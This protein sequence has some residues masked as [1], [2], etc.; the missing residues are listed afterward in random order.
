MECVDRVDGLIACV[1][2]VC[3]QSEFPCQISQ[4]NL[5]APSQMW[6]RSNDFNENEIA[7]ANIPFDKRIRPNDWH[8]YCDKFCGNV[9]FECAWWWGCYC[10]CYRCCYVSGLLLLLL[11]LLLSGLLSVFRSWASFFTFI[12][13]N[14]FFRRCS[15]GAVEGFFAS[16]YL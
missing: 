15:A 9:V 10:S 14:T 5:T 8:C 1:D 7:S 13:S 3:C 6:P 16:R 4:S 12:L 11:L 2:S